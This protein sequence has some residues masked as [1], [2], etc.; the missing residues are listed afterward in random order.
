[1]GEKMPYNVKGEQRNT[2]R[3]HFKKGYTHWNKG[4]TGVFSEVTLSK[5]SVAAKAR[6]KIK[7]PF[8]GKHHSDETK[9]RIALKIKALPKKTLSSKGKP[10]TMA[11]REAQKKVVFKKKKKRKQETKKSRGVK[12]PRKSF[13]ISGNEYPYFWNDLRKIIYKRDKWTCQECGVKCRDKKSKA[14]KNKIQCHHIDY[15]TLNSDPS[16]LLTLC[17]SCHAKTSFQRIDWI[18]HFSKTQ[19]RQKC[20]D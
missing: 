14:T 3:T 6:I 18:K 20:R 2:G 19:E 5:M 17:A 9:R 10:W 1:M 7:H 13:F 8:K 4:K 11:R 12:R 15:N 16:N